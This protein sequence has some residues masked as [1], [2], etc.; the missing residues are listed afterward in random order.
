MSGVGITPLVRIGKSGHF[1]FNALNSEADAPLATTSHAD[2]KWAYV[3][4]EV[5]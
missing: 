1:V 3:E 5:S 4:W 2:T